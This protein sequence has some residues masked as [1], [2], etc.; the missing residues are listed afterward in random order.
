M[1]FLKT[2]TS[3]ERGLIAVAAGVLLLLGAWQFVVSPVLSARSN[4]ERMQNAALRDFV[5]VRDG[6]SAIGG[7]SRAAGTR[8]MFD[9]SAIISV[10]RSAN[11]QISRV[12]PESDTVIKVWFE[13]ASSQSV[14]QFLST[15]EQGYAVKISRVQ[16]NRRDS[17]GVSA[18]IALEA[19]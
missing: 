10:A 14:F 3:R 11:L 7:V 12:Q 1:S 8:K 6:A 5:I 17:G 19:L 2:R 15:L 13:D 18:Q 16:I 9:R 4:A